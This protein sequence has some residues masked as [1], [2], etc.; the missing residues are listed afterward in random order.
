[1]MLDC[2]DAEKSPCQDSQELPISYC[3]STL[4]PSI[5]INSAVAFHAGDLSMSFESVAEAEIL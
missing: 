4:P 1:M 2:V 5:H 3:I